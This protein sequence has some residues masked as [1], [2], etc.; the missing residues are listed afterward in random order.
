MVQLLFHFIAILCSYEVGRETRA[1]AKRKLRVATIPSELG[2][3]I[4]HAHDPVFRVLS[5]RHADVV[6]I[7]VQ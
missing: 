2:C 3:E 5:A 4:Q 1:A 6:E 7:S